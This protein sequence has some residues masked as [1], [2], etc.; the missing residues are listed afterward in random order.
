MT[1]QGTVFTL[2]SF[3]LDF[4]SPF[5][6]TIYYVFIYIIYILMQHPILCGW[7]LQVNATSR[8]S[9]HRSSSLNSWKLGVWVFASTRRVMF[10][11]MGLAAQILFSSL[12]VG[13]AAH[14]SSIDVPK[15]VH[16]I[17][18]FFVIHVYSTYYINPEVSWFL[19]SGSIHF[20]PCVISTPGVFVKMPYHDLMWSCAALWGIG[21]RYPSYRH[22]PFLFFSF[23]SLLGF[24]VL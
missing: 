18:L 1:T 20:P 3:S 11:I 19:A 16:I 2:P 17:L 8:Y 5:L 22:C 23:F 9:R 12:P 13:S 21:V 14:Q 6:Y 10:M 15:H 7:H 4:L 24:Q